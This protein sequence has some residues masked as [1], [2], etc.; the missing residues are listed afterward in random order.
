MDIN[1]LINS[2]TQFA[3]TK[4][5]ALKIGQQLEVKVAKAY[6]EKN[7]ITLSL[8]NKS[9][10]VKSNQPVALPS[11]QPLKIQVTQVTPTIEFKIIQ[12][13]P[14]GQ[15]PAN[16]D[17]KALPG[18]LRL[19]L[20]AAA[21]EGGATTGH[22]RIIANN[23]GLQ[24][25]AADAGVKIGQQFE[26][27]VAQTN[28][29]AAKNT[30]TL[31][32]G[33]KDIN[34]QSSQP[35][36]LLPGQPLKI[37]VTQVTPHIEFKLIE[38]LPELK[39][40]SGQLQNP[41]ALLTG[42]R[43]TLGTATKEGGDSAIGRNPIQATAG[44]SGTR[45]TDSKLTLN[46]KTDNTATLPQQQPITAKIIA[47]AGNK[48]QLQFVTGASTTDPVVPK[49]I[50]LLNIR[51]NQLSNAPS[52]LKVGQNLNLE[53]VKT[54]SAPEFKVIALPPPIPEAKISALMAQFL[55]RH[56]AAPIFLN[57]L[58]KDLPAL[59]ENKS[60]SQALKDITAKI[61][62][63]LPPK[64]QLATHHGL[65]QSITHSGVFLEAKLP[66]TLSQS[67][68]IN[69]LPELIK[70]ES[71][72]QSLQRIATE[73]LQNLTQKQPTASQPLTQDAPDNTQE[74]ASPLLKTVK[75]ETTGGETKIAT[76]LTLG[77]D[78]KA[79]LLKFIHALKQEI[80]LQSEQKT[81]QTDLELLK[82]LQNKSEN[83]VAKVVL[84]QL[85][86]LP[87]ED[88][89]KQLWL[90]DLPFIDRQQADTVKIEIQRDR[91]N[92]QQSGNRDWSVNITITPPGLG[93]IHCAVSYRNDAINTF[94]QSR[95]SQTTALI[96][97][98]LDYLKNQLEASG[99][100]TGQMDAHD[101]IQQTQPAHPHQLAGKK[102]FDDKA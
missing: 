30:L 16:Q 76:P 97:H 81:N 25:T 17:A 38:P 75:P 69:A 91:D 41:K 56:E 82:N 99:L 13:E 32:L 64:E 79:N 55:P 61:I 37:Q 46:G 80:T 88:N 3:P 23:T 40:Q 9:I 49:P 14:K 10:S 29:A 74:P 57:Q 101:G 85:M 77:E 72:P 27:K 39:G 31:S 83:T 71:V 68:L 36:A 28:I 84:D 53:I 98:N 45:A 96:K 43:L 90:I 60:V 15:S 66:S 93:T 33:N 102:L 52:T 92:K 51:R 86:S 18:D 95:N 6:A 1:A 78:F 65:K 48:I 63:N 58:I 70:N 73:L 7:A 100:K 5:L 59:M 26:V 34:L 89:P 12:P 87:K 94:F 22:S 47:M 35:I 24:R 21:K 20:N 19:T 11:G 42:L 44:N 67:A 50:A 8:G 54:G 4:A 62:Q 2:K